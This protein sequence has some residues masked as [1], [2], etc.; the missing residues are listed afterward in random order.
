MRPRHR[1][2]PH[3]AHLDIRLPSGSRVEIDTPGVE[4]VSDARRAIS[5]KLAL[6][7][8]CLK[9]VSNTSAL[10]TT[11]R[12][13]SQGDKHRAG[14]ATDPEARC[15]RTGRARVTVA[16]RTGRPNDTAARCH[17]ARSTA[18]A[19]QQNQ[20]QG[21]TE[22]AAPETLRQAVTKQAPPEKRRL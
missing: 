14:H 3:M 18:Q 22:Q 21:V 9:L 4:K 12:K 15:H 19:M 2:P 8:C 17:R 20:W 11:Q 16:R 5:N 6:P 10:P 1:P 7:V 13:L